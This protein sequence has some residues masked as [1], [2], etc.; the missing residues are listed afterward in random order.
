MPITTFVAQRIL[1]VTLHGVVPVA[2]IHRPA[3]TVAKVDGNEAQVLREDQI[4]DVLLFEAKRRF[5]SLQNL[6][7]VR[8]LVARF[9][10]VVPE[11]IREGREV[12]EL[13]TARA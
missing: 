10:E 3:R 7:A 12:D 1:S 8:R 4:A 5:V 13:L 6:D 11:F 2:N 9:D